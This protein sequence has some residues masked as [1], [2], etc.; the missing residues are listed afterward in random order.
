MVNYD[1]IHF[2]QGIMDMVYW[3]NMMRSKGKLMQTAFA[4]LSLELFLAVYAI[5]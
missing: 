4:P 1:A 5:T 2:A 3:E